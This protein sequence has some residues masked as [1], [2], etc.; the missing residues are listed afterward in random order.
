[1]QYRNKYGQWTELVYNFK[2]C[3][4][5]NLQTEVHDSN[6]ARREARSD[7]ILSEVPR[8]LE[9]ITFSLCSKG[10]KQQQEEEPQNI[11]IK[12]CTSPPLEIVCFLG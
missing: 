11:L 10:Q 8:H 12:G 1:M 3:I 9:D 2:R 6:K 7:A 4:H 5:T